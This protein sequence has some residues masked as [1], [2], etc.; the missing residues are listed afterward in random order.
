MAKYIAIAWIF[1][2][3][4]NS[5][6]LKP[7]PQETQLTSDR[8]YPHCQG[9]GLLD[10]TGCIMGQFKLHCENRLNKSTLRDTLPLDQIEELDQLNEEFLT[11][12]EH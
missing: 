8:P 12:E 5:I 4:F 2:K 6:A 3:I 7:L 11:E 9:C 10:E 1:R